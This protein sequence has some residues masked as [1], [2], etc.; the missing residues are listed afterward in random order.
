MMTSPKKYL[1][2]TIVAFG[3]GLVM[4]AAIPVGSLGVAQSVRYED[5]RQVV[6]RTQTDLERAATFL[7]NNHKERDRL[8]NAQKSLST[9]DRHLAK[10]K[11]DKDTLDSAI[12]DIQHVLDNDVLHGQDRDT[13]LKDIED[14]R[15]VRADRG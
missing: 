3:I 2:S 10:G 11:F 5:A 4:P 9:L 1:R 8:R 6:G 14:L 12:S 7:A 13:L 15:G